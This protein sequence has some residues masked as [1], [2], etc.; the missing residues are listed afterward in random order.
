MTGRV[1]HRA[2]E[3]CRLCERGP[4]DKVICFGLPGRLCARCGCLDGLAAWAPPVPTE[5]DAGPMFAF[6]VYRGSYWRALWAW[7]T[8]PAA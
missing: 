4:I 8:R 5:T 3:Q 7:L 1:D 6:M 2:P